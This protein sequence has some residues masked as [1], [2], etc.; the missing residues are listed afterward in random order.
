[1][2]ADPDT[3]LSMVE[4]R[5]GLLDDNPGAEVP[6]TRPDLEVQFRA[7]DELLG[8]IAALS[9]PVD[10]PAGLLAR[11][12]RKIDALPRR[13][14]STL[15]AEEGKWVKRTSKIWQ[16]YLHNDKATGRAIYLL[17]CAPGAMIPPHPHLRD[18]HIFVIE[19]SF[20]VGGIAVNAGDSQFSKAG[21]LHRTTRSPAG[22]LV[23][24]HH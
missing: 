5:L 8:S 16:K 14:T 17:R 9:P 20:I 12:E 21:T 7:E 3:D 13:W 1:M 19:G 22:C 23:V 2:T 11:I 4:R 10:P 15:R 24:V 18:E 6:G